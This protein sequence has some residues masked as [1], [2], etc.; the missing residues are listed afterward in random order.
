MYDNFSDREYALIDAYL[1]GSATANERAELNAAM[2]QN[3]VLHEYVVLRKQLQNIGARKQLLRAAMLVQAD[4]DTPLP[5]QTEQ[6]PQPNPTQNIFQNIVKNLKN[7][8][9]SPLTYFAGGIATCAIAV[10]VYS[11]TQTQ[12]QTAVVIPTKT[13][14][15]SIK[16]PILSEN[17]AKN[18]EN[19]DFSI[20]KPVLLENKTKNADFT[21]KN[22]TVQA[23]NTTFDAKQNDK[24]TQ[25]ALLDTPKPILNTIANAIAKPVSNT[26]ASLNKPK[27][28]SFVV[29]QEQITRT[30]FP[31]PTLISK[32]ATPK[33]VD[34]NDSLFWRKSKM[35]VL[36]AVFGLVKDIRFSRWGDGAA[37]DCAECEA[38]YKHR[39]DLFYD[40][41]E[42]KKCAV[43]LKN[44][45]KMLRELDSLKV[46]YKT[47]STETVI[48]QQRKQRQK[49]QKQATIDE[50]NRYKKMLGFSDSL[51]LVQATEL[52][53]KN[54][55][56]GDEWLDFLV[57]YYKV[58]DRNA[59]RETIADEQAAQDS[60]RTAD[61]MV[62]YNTN[63]PEQAEMRAAEAKN[64]KNGFISIFI[65]EKK[66]DNR[67]IYGAYILQKN[68]IP[69]THEYNFYWKREKK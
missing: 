38:A 65:G 66:I 1:D 2:Q 53:A 67:G 11:L 58:A 12:T 21:I 68:N 51:A 4:L 61:M 14:F 5:P 52:C 6:M 18:N 47:K 7:L 57:A 29:K 20:K 54:W 41:D 27:K 22:T 16:Q 15:D 31:V 48:A 10:G 64:K 50:F 30:E 9:F 23:D 36:Q 49:Q 63:S 62:F 28:D 60:I 19:A 35:S 13:S 42:R 34:K 3:K 8:N 17:K 26:I 56:T 69:P 40:A 55:N 33:N 45:K 24:T 32:K 44:P 25:N 43:Y 59:L 46:L 37:Y 39:F